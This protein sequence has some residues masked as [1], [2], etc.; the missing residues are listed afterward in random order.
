MTKYAIPVYGQ[1]GVNMRGFCFLINAE[2]SMTPDDV[3]KAI[4]KSLC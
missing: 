1:D 3:L 4:K 2:D